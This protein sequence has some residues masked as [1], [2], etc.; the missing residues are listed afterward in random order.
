MIIPKAQRGNKGKREDN[1]PGSVEVK[2]DNRMEG[3]RTP[4]ARLRTQ[5]S[6][7]DQNSNETIPGIGRG[8]G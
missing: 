4:N 6:G 7:S 3:R 2:S 5:P 1:G 8:V